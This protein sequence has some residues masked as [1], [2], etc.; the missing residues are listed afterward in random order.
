MSTEVEKA[1]SA[2]K[3]SKTTIFDKIISKEIPAQII[4]EDDHCLAFHDVNPQAPTHFLV[5]PKTR[6]SCLDD[7]KE[8]DKEASIIYIKHLI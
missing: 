7:S 1:R 2:D 8:S 3:K 4:Y 5:I 6:I